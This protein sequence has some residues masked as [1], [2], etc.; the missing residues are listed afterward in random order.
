MQLLPWLVNAPAD[1]ND[2]CKR[3]KDSEDTIA[4]ITALA[5]TELS[6]NQCHRLQRFIATSTDTKNQLS[7]RLDCFKLGLVSNGTTDLLIPGLIISAL[8]YGISL[9][10][11]S[12]DFDQAMQQAVDPDSIINAAKPDAILIALDYRAFAFGSGTWGISPK[13]TSGREGIEQLLEIRDGFRKNCGAACILQTLAMPPNVVLG[14]IDSYIDGMLRSEIDRFNAE[15]IK[16]ISAGTDTL[17][18]IAS[19]VQRIGANHWFDERQWLMAR[20][21]MAN[22]YIPL[23]AEYVARLVSALRG[24]T[25]KCLVLDL[26]NTLWGGVIGDDGI[27]GIVIGQGSPAGEAYLSLQRYA[28]E[29]KSLGVILAVCSKNDDETARSVFREHPEM[30]IKENDIAAFTANWENKAGNLMEIARI[31]NIGLDS[32]VFVDD[33]PAER[34]IIRQFLPQVAVPELPADPAMVPRT[35][36]SAG[37]FET[38]TFNQEDRLRSEQYIANAQRNLALE[39]SGG[40]DEFL[41]SLEMKMTITPFDKIGR[42]RIT[43]LINK[44]NQFNLTTRRY[45]EAEVEKFETDPQYITLQVRLAD[46]F[47]DNGMVSVIICRQE[48][49]IWEIDTWLMSCRVIKR[50]AEDAICD[51]LVSLAKASGITLLR[52]L[53]IPNE[54]NALVSHHY[55]NL[56]FRR[57]ADSGGAEIWE[58]DITSYSEKNAPIEMVPPI[59]DTRSGS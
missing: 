27:A 13:G 28:L 44:T 46:R 24:K 5:T 7:T 58:M 14:N 2:R 21:P 48:G 26:D 6:V 31:L 23:Y 4:D 10:I 40:M 43:Q 39:G 33:N 19:I 12:S 53:Y 56:G 25:R 41:R 42:K 36:A 8:R 17:L 49:I 35:L 52:G 29:L 3:L 1:F 37:Y 16:T 47:G 9:D 55:E 20:L 30:L 11:V 34:D 59:K 54:R 45:K 32:L 38:V 15:L 57:S 22:E 51:E 50:R 18:D